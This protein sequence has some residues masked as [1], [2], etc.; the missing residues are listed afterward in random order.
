MGVWPD[1]AT[2]I[3]DLR[4]FLNDGPTDRP[5]KQKQLVGE[6]DGTNTEFFVWEERV[7]PGTLSVQVDYTPVASVL[8]DPIMGLV[9]I[10]PPPAGG[11]T[12]RGR[13]YYQYFLDAELQVAIQEA[14]TQIEGSDD[15]TTIIPAL[16]IVVLNFGGYFG[17][18]K[19]AIRWAQRMSDKWILKE[20]PEESD[21]FQKSNLFD[22]LARTFMDEGRILRDDYYKRQ[23][24][25]LAPAAAMMKPRIP[26]VGPRR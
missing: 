23:S 3:A 4:T 11:S 13:Y 18:K 8:S 19:Q 5:V 14:A 10:T 6:R 22:K 26:R 9:T 21:N 24:R 17:Y 15:V 2:A 20:S 1:L 12:V 7:V 16:K 25:Q